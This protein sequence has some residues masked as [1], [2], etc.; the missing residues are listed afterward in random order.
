LPRTAFILFFGSKTQQPK[1]GSFTAG[2]VQSGFLEVA[3]QKK[4]QA[5]TWGMLSSM[6]FDDKEA[7][8]E[9]KW[10]EI[11]KKRSSESR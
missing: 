1:S 10:N 3:A 9:A 4:R 6:L 5:S 7:N 2:M 11:M 8:K